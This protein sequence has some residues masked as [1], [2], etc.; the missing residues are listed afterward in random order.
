MAAQSKKVQLSDSEMTELVKASLKRT[1]AS[2]ATKTRFWS[3]ENVENRNVAKRLNE[4][5]AAGFEIFAVNQSLG[6]GG[7]YHVIYYVDKPTPAE[8]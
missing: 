7:S 1:A 8:E 3:Q 6:I 4:L 5:S 2:T